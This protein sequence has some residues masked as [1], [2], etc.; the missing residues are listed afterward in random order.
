[1]QDDSADQLHIEMAHA[2]GAYTRFSH[3]RESFRQNLHQ[4]FLL[5]MFTVVFIA[6]VLDGLGDLRLEESRALAH[7]VIGELLNLWLE[8]IDLSNPRTNA[9][10]KAFVA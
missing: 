2:G 5:A 4:R 8:L 1:M 3:Q 9:F 10:Q 7:L 6:R